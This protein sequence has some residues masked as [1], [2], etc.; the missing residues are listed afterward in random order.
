[1][2]IKA[3]QK[4]DLLKYYEEFKKEPIVIN[5]GKEYKYEAFDEERITSLP[6]VKSLADQFINNEIGLQ[7]FK[8]RSS[9]I[10]I[11][12]PY[13]G[14]KAMSGQMQLNQYNNNIKSS[15]KENLLRECIKVPQNETEAA[16]KINKM[17]KYIAGFREARF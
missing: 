6:F 16:E 5:S 9:E 17:S 3:E 2:I 12:Y 14:F 10:C 4:K 8:E 11:K 13:W 15:N 1:M 7:E